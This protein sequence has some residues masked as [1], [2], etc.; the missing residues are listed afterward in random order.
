MYKLMTAMNQV[1]TGQD[2]KIFHARGK[3]YIKG[4]IG[5]GNLILAVNSRVRHLD[6]DGITRR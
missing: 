5:T 1:G 6:T 2:L 3:N 4:C